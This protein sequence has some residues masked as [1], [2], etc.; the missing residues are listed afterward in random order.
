MQRWS[1]WAVAVAAD[2]RPLGCEQ[3]F[4]S[5]SPAATVGTVETRPSP[6][7]SFSALVLLITSSSCP[8]LHV[9]TS[10]RPVLTLAVVACCAG[11]VDSGTGDAAVLWQDAS[12]RFIQVYT[13]QAAAG[14]V[15]VEPMSVRNQTVCPSRPVPALRLGAR[16]QQRVG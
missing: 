6:P 5:V 2:G 8:G 3:G 14:V 11:I 13:G 10:S 7:S 16:S 15:A 12:H 4:K 9:A 1:A